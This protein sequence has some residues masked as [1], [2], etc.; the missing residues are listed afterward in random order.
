MRETEWKRRRRKVRRTSLGGCTGFRRKR[1]DICIRN[2]L[3]C[4]KTV[5]R[6]LYPSIWLPLYSKKHSIRLEGCLRWLPSYKKLYVSRIVY[7]NKIIHNVNIRRDAI[8]SAQGV[9]AD[10]VFRA[11]SKLLFGC[12]VC[13]GYTP[14]IISNWRRKRKSFHWARK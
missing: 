9:K 14:R 4:W 7:A 1:C 10:K 2:C 3:K 12:L 5:L 13:I 11:I 6:T 8:D